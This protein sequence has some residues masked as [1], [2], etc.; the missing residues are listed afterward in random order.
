MV[1]RVN[2]ELEH[3]LLKLAGGSGHDLLQDIYSRFVNYNAGVDA[4]RFRADRKDYRDEIRRLENRQLIQNR[5]EEVEVYRPLLIALPLINEESAKRTLNAADQI[6]T[7][8]AKRYI[9][10]PNCNVSK[11]EIVAN[12]DAPRSE[13]CMALK[14]LKETPAVAGGST[15]FPAT[16]DSFTMT[17]EQLLD[18]DSLAP[19]LTQLAEWADYSSAVP[20]TYVDDITPDDPG[21]TSLF[22]TDL[23]GHWTSSLPDGIQI[24]LREVDRGAQIGLVTL[25]A[26][27]IRTVIEMV[28]TEKIENAGTLPAKVD[29]LVKKG[30]L[31][32]TSADALKT[33]VKLGNATAHRGYRPESGDLSLAVDV[34]CGLLRE[35]YHISPRAEGLRERVPNH[36]RNK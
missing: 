20:V 21:L 11:A 8:L 36:N 9:A 35:L 2:A 1:N 16:D 33:V 26:F 29:A 25:P 30:L 19:L 12:V 24:V 23:A 28:C 7:Y 17:G 32:R 10:S 15:D 13:T 3:R 31:T 22:D 14:Y 18:F 5:F 27:G 34:L 4:K 6:L